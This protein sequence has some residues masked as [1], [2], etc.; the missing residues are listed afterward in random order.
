MVGGL[1]PRAI[2]SAGVVGAEELS[3]EALEVSVLPVQDVPEGFAVA[4]VDQRDEDVLRVVRGVL[5]EL[6]RSLEG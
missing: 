2:G 6:K 5:K 4:R 3:H 1:G